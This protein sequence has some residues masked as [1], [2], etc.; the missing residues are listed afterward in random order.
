[1]EIFIKKTLLIVALIL[2]LLGC[3]KKENEIQ[4]MTQVKIRVLDAET[5]KV[6]PVMAC[7]TGV[8]DGKV[9]IPTLAEATD[10][11]SQTDVFY[12]GIEYNKN[13]NWIGPIRKMNGLGNNDDRSYVYDRL[14]SIPHWAAPVAYQI[15]GDFSI[16]L[17]PGTWR[18]SLG[19]GNEYIPIK[20]EFTV[21]ENKKEITLTFLLKRWINLPK[22]N[23][24]SGD[25]HVHHPTNKPEFKEFLLEYAR[26]EDIHVVNVLEMGHHLGTEFKQEGFGEK[27]RTNEG[28]IWLVSGQED[29][30][31]TF[32]HIIGL[33][34]NQMERDTSTY[35]YYDLVFKKLQLQQGA[36]VGYAHFSWNGC[37]L[38]RGFPWYIT[39]G[40]IDF[41]ELLQFS[42]I[43]TMDYYDYLNLGFRITAAAGSD[44]PWGSTLGEVRTF[45]YTG[46]TFSADAW[47]EGL[48]SGHTFVSNG[49]ALFLD[50]DGL[51][52]G[53]EIIQDKGYTS[54]VS[55]KAISNPGI[56]NI[57]RV[58]IYN[59]DGLVTEMH[60][61]E[62]SD[63]LQIS[64]LH[65][66]EKSQWLAAVVYCDNG[67]VAHTTP[68][69]FIVDG[70]PTWSTQNAPSIIEKQM[71][72]IDLIE[73]ETLAKEK[74]DQGILERLEKAKEVYRS[75]LQQIDS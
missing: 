67:A 31:S 54:N 69:Y 7:I 24:Y 35:N 74:I 45:V 65:A 61:P 3:T 52:P 22:L 5:N 21:P 72:A 2:G 63:S 75:I 50:A 29:P 15:S 43:N 48:K 10:S 33:N 57:E 27:F 53:T 58:A 66:L 32:G 59:N 36:I 17:P 9:R 40:D 42:K 12:K 37:D 34:I 4:E 26:A 73:E 39:A 30:R 14:P 55:V 38:P 16:K 51:L 68:I 8:P 62:K 70:K 18:I 71:D 28:D 41:V 23:W 49:P 19:H 56:G 1:M 47:F 13:K 44:V 46:N 64:L 20:E 11:V 6:T 60:N 25:V